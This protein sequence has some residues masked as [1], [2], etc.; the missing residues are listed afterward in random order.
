MATRKRSAAVWAAGIAAGAVSGILAERA[1][2]KRARARPDP[3]R[4]ER[5]DELPGARVPV[6]GFDGIRLHVRAVGPDDGPIVVFVHGVTLNLT[7]WHYQ[8]KALSDRYRCVLYDQRGHGLSARSPKL[9]YSIR[10]L[11]RDLRSVLDAVTPAGPVVLVGHSMGGMAIVAL[12]D[13]FPEEFGG[14][15]AGVVLADTTASDAVK[16]AIGALGARIE[17][18]LR[19]L[20][21]WYTSDLDRIERIRARV[22][23]TGTD[24]AYLVARATNFGPDASP[25]QVE[26]VTCIAT[27]APSEVWTHAWRSIFEMDLRHGLRGIQ[28]PAL[29]IVGDRDRLT[30]KTSAEALLRNLPQGRGAVLTGAG[31]IAM[32]ER[33]QAFTRLLEGFLEEVL[34]GRGAS[35]PGQRPVRS[36]A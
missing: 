10:A 24:L 30:P 33:H 14:R 15:V 27:D 29:V 19:P 5:F 34:A 35:R 3:E 22:R 12:A 25:A 26:Y 7:T 4:G 20:A 13:E 17:R 2:M 28:V 9:D 31:H 18:T 16:E 6:T 23:R 8:W 1:A 36:T 32:M 21:T 11:G